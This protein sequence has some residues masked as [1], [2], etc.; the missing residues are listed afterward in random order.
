MSHP[1]FD[2]HVKAYR[3]YRRELKQRLIKKW[4]K[5]MAARLTKAREARGLTQLQL[6]ERAGVAWAQVSHYENGVRPT[7]D[8]LRKLAVA[9]D[10][11]TDW[12]LVLTNRGG[13]E[14]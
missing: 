9:L 11:S 10:V 6:G 13:P 4:V 7:V 12:M 3:A 8:N 5:E 1:K 2:T 14:P